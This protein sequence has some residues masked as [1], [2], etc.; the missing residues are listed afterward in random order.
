MGKLVAIYLAIRHEMIALWHRITC[1]LGFH[2]VEERL[3]VGGRK[4]FRNS[5]FRCRWCK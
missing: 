5:K 3:M 1:S 2:E 4:I